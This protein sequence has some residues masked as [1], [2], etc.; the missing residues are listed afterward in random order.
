MVQLTAPHPP[1][2]LRGAPCKASE[3]LAG[4]HPG[5]VLVAGGAPQ[6]SCSWVQPQDT[7][8]PP[9]YTTQRSLAACNEGGSSLL[10]TRG[11]Y[12]SLLV[13]RRGRIFPFPHDSPFETGTEHL[14][15]ST[16]LGRSCERG[17]EKQDLTHLAVQGWEIAVRTQ[18]M[19]LIARC[20]SPGCSQEISW[21]L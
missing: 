16:T 9:P 6:P 19:Q 4:S 18:S 14:K 17:K 21:A 1:A 13:Q 10:W 20:S 2:D 12:S 7:W 3:S 5:S 15:F 8:H 11:R